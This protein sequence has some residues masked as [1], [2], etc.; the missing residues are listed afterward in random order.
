MVVKSQKHGTGKGFTTPNKVVEWNQNG[1]DLHRPEQTLKNSRRSAPG[2][3]WGP[4]PRISAAAAM[5][6][7]EVLKDGKFVVLLVVHYAT[8]SKP[9]E[10]YNQTV[11]Q[12]ALP[13]QRSGANS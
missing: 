3:P 6:E 13:R 5:M 11:G 8:W 1:P 10:W 7:M 2:T 9:N 4:T 12:V